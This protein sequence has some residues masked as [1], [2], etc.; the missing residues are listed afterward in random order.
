MKLVCVLAVGVLPAL[1][2]AAQ[3]TAGTESAG[4]QQKTTNHRLSA[5]ALY[6]RLRVPVSR[7]GGHALPSYFP[8]Q[9]YARAK[10]EEAAKDAKPEQTLP[11]PCRP[12]A[13][14]AAKSYVPVGEPADMK[15]V[16]LIPPPSAVPVKESPKMPNVRALREVMGGFLEKRAVPVSLH[17]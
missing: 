2:T 16:S 1:R 10:Q 12:A 8:Y 11:P 15:A 17:H 4:T 7:S 3:Q 14:K 13:S 5:A 6:H 9:E